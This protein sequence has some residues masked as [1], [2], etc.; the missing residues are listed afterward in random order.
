M[1]AGPSVRR[2]GGMP[3]RA[4]PGIQPASPTQLNCVLGSQPL[5]RVLSP[6]GG[7]P[8]PWTIA[9]S[10]DTV[11]CEMRSRMFCVLNV[12]EPYAGGDGDTSARAADPP[13]ASA[14][15]PAARPAAN[16]DRCMD[17]LP[18]CCPETERELAFRGGF[19]QGRVI[20]A[21]RLLMQWSESAEIDAALGQPGADRR[22]R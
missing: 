13:T 17:E 16:Q 8:S 19:C 18:S 5:L 15:A 2:S 6:G 12:P 9:T 4:T 10:S 7:S 20:K 1:P 14:R 11:I 22:R 21:A 3:R